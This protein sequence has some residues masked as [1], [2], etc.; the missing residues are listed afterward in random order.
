M[1]RKDILNPLVANN[2]QNLIITERY[3]YNEKIYF[4]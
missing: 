4:F 3:L 1:S 2:S